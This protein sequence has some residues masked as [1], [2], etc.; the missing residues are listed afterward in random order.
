VELC[1]RQQQRPVIVSCTKGTFLNNGVAS[2]QNAAAN[3]VMHKERIASVYTNVNCHVSISTNGQHSV[4]SSPS[5]EQKTTDGSITEAV[6]EGD[7]RQLCSSTTLP[8][9]GSL[10][11]MLIESEKEQLA[12]EVVD[13]VS[14]LPANAKAHRNAVKLMHTCSEGAQ[15]CTENNFL[16]DHPYVKVSED[17]LSVFFGSPVSVSLLSTKLKAVPKRKATVKSKHEAKDDRSHCHN[18]NEHE[19][20]NTIKLSQQCLLPLQDV[21]VKNVDKPCVCAYVTTS[22]QSVCRNSDVGQL[23]CTPLSLPV[24]DTGQSHPA[25]ELNGDVSSI[26]QLSACQMSPSSAALLSPSSASLVASLHSQKSSCLGSVYSAVELPVGSSGF[27]HDKWSGNCTSPRLVSKSLGTQVNCCTGYSAKPPQKLVNDNCTDNPKFVYPSLAYRLPVSEAFEHS[28]DDKS[29]FADKRSRSLFYQIPHVLQSGCLMKHKKA[30]EHMNKTASLVTNNNDCSRTVNERIFEGHDIH[31]ESMLAPQ[32]ENSL[33]TSNV[34]SCASNRTAV[35][36]CRN[37]GDKDTAC[38]TVPECAVMET[39]CHNAREMPQ[40]V[41]IESAASLPAVVDTFRRSRL[42]CDFVKQTSRTAFCDIGVQT[43][44]ASEFASNVSKQPLLVNAAVQTLSQCT[45][46]MFCQLH[47]KRHRSFN[48]QDES[49]ELR[50]NYGTHNTDCETNATDMS[51][52]L[53]VSNRDILPVSN[54]DTCENLSDVHRYGFQGAGTLESESGVKKCYST[55]SYGEVKIVSASNQIVAATN[56]ACVLTTVN[57]G[58]KCTVTVNQGASP[59]SADVQHV[60]VPQF[61]VPAK[62]SANCF[63]AGVLSAAETG[64]LLHTA[65]DKGKNTVRMETDECV[66]IRSDVSQNSTN[67]LPDFFSTGFISAGGKPLSVKLSSKLNANKLLDEFACTEV[68]NL[69]NVTADDKCTVNADSLDF[70]SV[71]MNSNSKDTMSNKSFKA[72]RISVMSSRYGENNLST[73]AD[74]ECVH[75]TSTCIAQSHSNVCDSIK[76]EDKVKDVDESELLHDLTNTQLAEVVDASLLVLNSAELFAMPSSDNVNELAV[77][78]SVSHN[79]A[80][81]AVNIGAQSSND[82]RVLYCN[83]STDN[84]NLFICSSSVCI[85][86]SANMERMCENLLTGQKQHAGNETDTEDV[87]LNNR[88]QSV[89]C[90]S[91]VHSDMEKAES[92]K[93]IGQNSALCFVTTCGSVVSVQEDALRDIAV[94]CNVPTVLDSTYSKTKPISMVC[95]QSGQAGAVG[96][97][98]GA[99]CKICSCADDNVSCL[100]ASAKQEVLQSAHI[101]ANLREKCCFQSTCGIETDINNKAVEVDKDNRIC[102]NS[103]FAFFSAKGS[104][105]GVNE[106]TLCRVRESWNNYL[107]EANSIGMEGRKKVK[108]AD[109]NELLNKLHSSQEFVLQTTAEDMHVSSV[110]SDTYTHG[111]TVEELIKNG[112]CSRNATNTCENT[113]LSVPAIS[114]HPANV[115]STSGIYNE[116]FGQNIKSVQIVSDDA[117]ISNGCLAAVNA[118]DSS[119]S[120]VSSSSIITTTPGHILPLRASS[121]CKNDA[122]SGDDVCHSDRN[123]P[124]PLRSI[125]ESK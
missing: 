14:Y 111:V 79:N 95:L 98:Q 92:A 43:D 65:V 66:L 30:E 24:S 91:V 25:A 72:P 40:N 77:G 51:C 122:E 4:S 114:M 36:C 112:N 71:V 46:D 26:N 115:Q 45:C 64:K 74:D 16:G 123:V 39:Y 7:V 33:L 42:A 85:T 63:S 119:V 97:S 81:A 28:S 68:N 61:T 108:V 82:E 34:L 52:E 101:S 113:L 18:Y 94:S 47:K 5:S 96:A 103:P 102:K 29:L 12:V 58:N 21:S 124:V 76:L 117:G 53:L 3:D 109:V 107:N 90:S 70:S 99:V 89:T 35:T 48:S 110:A 67:V 125:P 93:N 106:K 41:R 80:T 62:S 27:V 10:A 73:K 56:T 37:T 31:T 60:G 17:D 75:G 32:S 20:D 8:S 2:A 121:L 54:V 22:E 78:Q 118:A 13:T 104:K 6:S 105:I 59:P 86:P 50:H 55:S 87:D 116:F 49:N 57:Y 15:N 1:N 88:F 120:C 44:L 38:D 84:D 9:V 69:E 100:C 83:V 19:L 11:S 23:S